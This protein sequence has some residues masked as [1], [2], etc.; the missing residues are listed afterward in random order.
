VRENLSHSRQ[1]LTGHNLERFRNHLSHVRSSRLTIPKE[2]AWRDLIGSLRV[3]NGESV[4]IRGGTSS[5]GLAAAELAKQHGLA[6]FSTTR[7]REKAEKIVPQVGGPDHVIIE[8]DNVGEALLKHTKGKGVEYCVDLVGGQ[9]TLKH[10]AQALKPGK[11]FCWPVGRPA[12]G[13]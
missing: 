3:Q 13:L 8:E 1:A 2:A 11:V 12:L 6:V 9:E 5:V 10:S 4:L 7:S